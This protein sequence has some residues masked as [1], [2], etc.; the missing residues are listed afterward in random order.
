MP[1]NTT[2]AGIGNLK[3]KN[4]APAIMPVIK[5]FMYNIHFPLKI[6]KGQAYT[7]VFSPI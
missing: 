6:E 4:T 3:K 2:G 5:H 1:S 7:E